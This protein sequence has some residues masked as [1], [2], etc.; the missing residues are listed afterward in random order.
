MAPQQTAKFRTTFL[1]NFFTSLRKDSVA[2]NA[3]IW[4]Q[5]SPI[6]RGLDVF[7]KSL[8]DCSYS[9]KWRHKIRKFA[10]KIFQNVK[11]GRRV[12]PNTSVTIYIVINST[13]SRRP[14]AACAWQ[15]PA[16]TALPSRW[17]FCFLVTVSVHCSVRCFSTQINFRH[18]FKMSAFGKMCMFW[19]VNAAECHWSMD[20]SLIMRCSMLCQTFI[21]INERNE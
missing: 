15:Y 11:I 7:Y 2:N 20:A 1:V 17:C 3:S 9:G 8:N 6:V 5:F 4:T 16:G 18:V 12:V 19:V 14:I 10:V 13:H 21:L